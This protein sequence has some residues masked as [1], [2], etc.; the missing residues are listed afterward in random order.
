MLDLHRREEEELRL[1]HERCA[2]Q[3]WFSEEWNIVNTAY[4]IQSQ[5]RR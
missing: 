1:R 2:M 4:M 3:E 5:S